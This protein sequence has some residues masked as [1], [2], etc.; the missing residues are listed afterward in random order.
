M[1]QVGPAADRDPDAYEDTWQEKPPTGA[2]PATAKAEVASTRVFL[3]NLSFQIDE[4][5]LKEC[6]KEYGRKR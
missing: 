1:A 5:I 2:A 3:G 6:F 4:D